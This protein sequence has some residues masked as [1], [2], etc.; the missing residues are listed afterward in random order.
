MGERVEDDDWAQRLTILLSPDAIPQTPLRRH[1]PDEPRNTASATNSP[2]FDIDDNTTNSDN[3]N[4][5]PPP[6][7]FVDP[8][9]PPPLPPHRRPHGSS[10][11]QNPPSSVSGVAAGRSPAGALREF[12]G[13][14]GGMGIF[15][16]P[17]RAAVHPG[18]PPS[19]ELRPRPLRETQV[20]SFLRTIACSDSQLWAGQ[21]SG[22][23]FWNLSD[24]FEGWGTGVVKRGDEESAPFW[25]SCRTSP[26]LCLAVDDASGLVWSGHKDGKIRSWRMEQPAPRNSPTGKGGNFKEGLSWRAHDSPVLSIVITSYGELWSGSEG[27]V[28]RAWSWEA[29]EKSLSLTIEEGHMTAS[30]VERSY[31]DL[32]SLVTV[33]GVCILPNMDVRY[34]LSD[35][36]RSKVWSGGYLSFAL[37]D[38]HTKELLKVFNIDGQV[39]TRFDTL[40]VHD[41]YEEH[42][43]KMNF[44]TI[45][46]KEKQR[47]PV[48]FFQRSRNALMGAA[49]VVRRVAVKGAFGDDNRR[50][51]ALTMTVD[52]MIWTGCANGLVV[53]WDGDGIRLQEVRHHSSSVQCLCT[54]G[55]RLWVGYVDGTVQVMDLDGC[56]LGR[57]IAHSSPVIKMAVGGSYIFTLANHGGIRGWNLASPG[58][59]DGIL[60]SVLTHKEPFYTKTEHLKILVGTWNVGQEKASCESLI[61]WLGGASSEVGVVVVGLQEVEMGAGFLAMAV[62]KETVGLE[63]SANGQWW[64]DAIGKILGEGNYFERVGS[65]QL[66]GLLV[67]VW[68]RKYLQPYIGDVDTAAVPCGFGRAI[69][70]KGAVGL[71]MRIYDRKMCFVNCHFAAHMEAVNRRNDDFDHVFRTMNFD[72][73]FIA[74]HVAAD[75]VSAVQLPR[76]SNTPGDGKPELSDADMAIFFGDFN[77]RLQ[78]ITYDETMDLISRSCFDWL[79]ER[80]QLQAEMRAGRVFQGL[81]EGEIKFPPTYKFERLQAGLSAYDSSE[82]KRIPAWCDRILYRDSHSVS[83]AQCSLES[84]VVSSISLYDSCMDVTDSD[85]KP[86]RCI[87]NVDIACV[88]ELSRRQE[89]GDIIASNERVKCLLEEI[90]YVPETVFN[91]YNIILQNQDTSMLRITNKCK[92]DK[93]MFG[94]TCEGHSIVKDDGQIS[95]LRTRASFGF[96]SWLKITPTAGIIKPGHMIDVSLHHEDLDTLEYVD[97]I[98]RN[99]WH[100]DTGG[101]VAILMVN[102]RGSCSVKSRS[103]RAQVRHI[104]S[105]TSFNES[106]GT[107][108]QIQSNPQ[109]PDFANSSGSSNVVDLLL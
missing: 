20:G 37:W 98:P 90:Q 5:S 17:P 36:S 50:T 42:E 77:Y 74:N 13:R 32:R 29:I 30:L 99:R 26:T 92:R 62:A 54:F 40:S 86:V 3:S 57:W 87:F 47:G 14:G 34:L 39:E 2:F 100:E 63:G 25:E 33:G 48:S 70:N 106:R 88:D 58:P 69:G 1:S 91:T 19:L 61:S 89:F 49:D 80:D 52:G 81:R 65:R 18:R 104:S 35:N 31:V 107:S 75:G 83:G 85:H 24:V 16:V 78:G 22:V 11:R 9:L 38:S 6:S 97:G 59:L 12:A 96:P 64:L 95:K 82:K 84:P 103:Y 93:A 94:I 60:R 44:V 67:A 28:I 27:G 8:H 76:G 41:L 55:M 51:E 105:T 15:Q 10:D 108:K 71:R 102:I 109:R 79:R 45:S 4:S 101:K 21:E 43:M 68:A 66:A 23:R 46:K 56:L 53:Q 7:L 73:P 72:R